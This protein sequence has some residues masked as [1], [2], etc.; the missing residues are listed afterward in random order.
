MSSSF[1]PARRR[2]KTPNPAAIKNRAMP[3]PRRQA[4][5]ACN[6]AADSEEGQQRGADLTVEH[7]A[8]NDAAASA[9]RT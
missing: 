1:W 6:D 2:A 8:S 4:S 9:S 7:R 3:C 5:Y